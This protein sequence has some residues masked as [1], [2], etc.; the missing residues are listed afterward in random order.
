MLEKGFASKMNKQ[1]SCL[2]KEPLQTNIPDLKFRRDNKQDPEQTTFDLAGNGNLKSFIGN[3]QQEG[4][5][6]NQVGYFKQTLP[7]FSKVYLSSESEYSSNQDDSDNNSD[8]C[9]RDILPKFNPVGIDCSDKRV[10]YCSDSPA[11]ACTLP[12]IDIY[13]LELDTTQ[14]TTDTNGDHA[15]IKPSSNILFS[16]LPTVSAKC[17]KLKLNITLSA[18]HFKAGEPIRGRLEITSHTSHDLL[19]KDISVELTG[20]EQLTPNSSIYKTKNDRS[21]QDQ[22]LTF[23]N[24]KKIFQSSRT[25]PSLAVT[26]PKIDGFYTAVKGKTMFEFEFD[27]PN[28]SPSSYTFQHDASLVYQITGYI[29]INQIGA[30]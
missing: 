22:T 8:L 3:F 10:N 12:N 16:P 30:I 21:P 1:N 9:E 6:A 2:L 26:G 27:L 23:I 15:Q 17:S 20:S 13:T 11:S 5:S 14:S 18:T 7:T 25:S 19:I 29:L 28:D 4:N 24:L